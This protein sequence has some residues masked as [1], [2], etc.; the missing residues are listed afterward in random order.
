M[1][2]TALTEAQNTEE[3]PSERMGEPKTGPSVRRVPEGDNRTRLV[4]PDCGYIEYDNPKIVVGAIC[5]WEDRILM[6][7]RA[8]EPRVGFWTFPAGF[9]ENNESLTA[10]AAR[11]V[12]EEAGA[13]VEIGSMI[14]IYEIPAIHQVQMFWRAT[15]TSPDFSPGEE[16]LDARL[17]DW[18]DIPWDNLAFPAVRWALEC[19]GRGEAGPQHHVADKAGLD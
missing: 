1:P 12:Y 9:L 16:S 5:T 18:A 4:C 14:G 3:A 6:C 17:M 19:Y 8:I 13:R 15:L 2:D 7:T 10:G 11:E